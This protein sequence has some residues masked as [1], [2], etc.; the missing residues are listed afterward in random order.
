MRVL[1]RID[2]GFVGFELGGGSSTTLIIDF[3]EEVSALRRITT[4]IE[5]FL[6]ASS[7]SANMSI[8]LSLKGW[9]SL[10]LATA[11]LWLVEHTVISNIGVP[12][13]PKATRLWHLVLDHA[14]LVSRV[15]QVHALSDWFVYF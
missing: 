1:H 13:G 8:S 9:I 12:I 3:T 14:G 5:V 4:R 11:I 10:L 6:S 2:V 7:Q 15:W